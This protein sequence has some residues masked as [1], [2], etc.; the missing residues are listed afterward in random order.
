MKINSKNISGGADSNKKVLAR[1]PHPIERISFD[2]L[3]D[4]FSDKAD[5]LEFQHYTYTFVIKKQKK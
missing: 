1:P 5:T 2:E 4:L 3:E